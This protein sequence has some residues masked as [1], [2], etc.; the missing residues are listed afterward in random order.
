MTQRILFTEQV[1]D[2]ANNNL[3]VTL[4]NL[5]NG[6]VTNVA[7]ATAN[8]TAQ[9]GPLILQWFTITSSPSGSSGPFTS[10]F[11]FAFPTGCLQCYAQNNGEGP[12]IVNSFTASAVT[13][14]TDFARTG[15]PASEQYFFAVGH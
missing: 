13:W 1:Q 4:S 14:Y 5:A 9:L 15:L 3:A 8:S 7:T 11:P 6:A 2:Q 12:V 10:N